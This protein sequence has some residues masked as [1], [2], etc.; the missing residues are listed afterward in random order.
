MGRVPYLTFFG[1]TN[2]FK[3]DHGQQAFLQAL[4]PFIMKYCL[5]LQVV[6]SVWLE[7]L[8]LWLC[9]QVAFLS[10][11]T[12]IE[13]VLF[14]LVEKMSKNIACIT[15]MLAKCLLTMATFDLWMSMGA[16]DVFALVVNLATQT[17][18]N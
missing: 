1:Y 11:K 5:P 6:E 17:H 3:K 10:K 13:K 18:H 7:P 8:A 15:Y 12:F 16:H 14:N 9:P 2:P 4:V